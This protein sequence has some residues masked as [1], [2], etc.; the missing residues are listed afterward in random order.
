MSAL[1]A[2]VL[3]RQVPLEN[4][5]SRVSVYAMKLQQQER[6]G[7]P[8]LVSVLSYTMRALGS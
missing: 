6:Q 4:V 1:K 7:S 5:T 8:K 3:K 2:I